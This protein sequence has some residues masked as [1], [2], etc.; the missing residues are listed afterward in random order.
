MFNFEP[1]KSSLAEV[2]FD[3]TDRC[4]KFLLEDSRVINVISNSVSNGGRYFPAPTHCIHGGY[5]DAVL[6]VSLD[7][8]PIIIEIQKNVD[9]TFMIR[10]TDYAIECGKTHGEP[11]C[12]CFST[13]SITQEVRDVLNPSNIE[14]RYTYPCHSWPSHTGEN[15]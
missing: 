10:F 3:C 8:P 13:G 6:K 15:S 5:S 2:M 14:G 4:T 1:L 9:K 12:I 7:S 11:I